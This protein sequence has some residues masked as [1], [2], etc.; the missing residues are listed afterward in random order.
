MASNVNPRLLGSSLGAIALLLA[1]LPAAAGPPGL[2]DGLDPA[3]A[4]PVRA[5]LLAESPTV[6]PGGTVLLGVHLSQDPGWHT[7]WRYGGD[8]GLPT[9]VRWRVPEGFMVGPLRWPTPHRYEEQG[10]LVAYG[11]SGDVVL[12]AELSAPPGGQAGDSVRIEASVDWLMCKELCIPDSARVSLRLAIGEST[13]SIS[14]QDRALLQSAKDR[15]PAPPSAHE[16]LTIT[17]ALELSAVPPGQKTHA[18]VRIEGL[19][20]P[21]SV[22]WVWFPAPPEEVFPGRPLGRVAD[23]ALL[24]GL[25]LE[26]DTTAAPGRTLQ[27]ENVLELQVPG[28]ETR[29]IEFSIPLPVSAPDQEISAVSE[30][31]FAQLLGGGEGGGLFEID[32]SSVAGPAAATRSLGYYLLLALV[33]GILLNVMPCVLPVISLKVLGFVQHANEDRAVVLRLG[34]MFALGVLASF[35]ALALVVIG[36]QAAGDQLGWGFQF[37]N[38][39]FVVVMGAV[40]FAFG[41]SLFGVYELVLP[42]S[43]GAAGGRGGAYAESF[44]SGVLATALATPCTAPLLGTALG[45]AFTQ[46]AAS[47]LAIFLTVGVGLALP[48]V[49]LSVNPAWLRFVPRPG[50]WMERFKQAMG[51]L[52]MATVVWLLWVLGQQIG[53][54]GIVWTLAFLLALGLGLWLYGAFVDLSSGPLRRTVMLVVVVLLIGGSAW[55]F[56]REPLEREHPAATSQKAHTTGGIT[57]EP[58]SVD[59]LEAAVASGRT[60]FV[61]F[62]AAW[63][64]TCKVNERTVLANDEVVNRLREYRVLTMVGDWT[65]RDPVITQVLRKFGRS[66]VPF[67]AIFPAGALDAPIVLPELITANLVL[68]ALEEAGPSRRGPEPALESAALSRGR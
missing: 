13:A 56:L 6:E 50:P 45:F 15:L 54:E 22:E 25:P 51:F 27:L 59:G 47:I 21:A 36:L 4:R 60:V 44:V 68:E 18:A 31:I 8:S 34:L 17:P 24:L 67:Y 63:C 42:V 1:T 41:L 48:Y 28:G 40:V 64:W 65:N 29:F 32:T 23:D 46:P 52:L 7:Y 3:A 39:V 38:P 53:T 62:T 57:W 55:G 30:D 14:P 10:D 2:G 19:A 66:G 61:D 43:F 26:L 49:V 20:D 35:L 12:L 58:F 33:G 11:Y 5:R 16:D 37:Q 9:R